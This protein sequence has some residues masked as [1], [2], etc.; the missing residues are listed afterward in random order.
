M[1]NYFLIVILGF[2]ERRV[3]EIVRVNIF[4]CCCG[5]LVLDFSEL[6]Y[7]LVVSVFFVCLGLGGRLKVER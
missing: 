7:V 2:K 3:E 6:E 1:F 4:C 5:V